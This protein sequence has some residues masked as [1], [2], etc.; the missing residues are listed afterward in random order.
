MAVISHVP[1]NKGFTVVNEMLPVLPE[2]E[3]SV[4]KGYR[5]KLFFGPQSSNSQWAQTW[6]K[7][8]DGE[9]GST[10]DEHS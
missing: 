6:W 3:V 2:E 9:H 5:L 10:L 4:R 7:V 8:Q 1:V